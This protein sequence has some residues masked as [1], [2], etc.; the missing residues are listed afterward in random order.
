MVNFLLFDGYR[1]I[2]NNPTTHYSMDKGVNF[3]IGLVNNGAS[4][5]FVTSGKTENNKINYINDK[6]ITYDF[7]EKIDIL[8]IIREMTIEEIFKQNDILFDILDKKYGNNKVYKKLKI[9][10]KSD[11]PGWIMNK[12][13]R[14][15]CREKYKDISKGWARK[16]FDFV[17][18]QSESFK[19][20]GKEMMGSLNKLIYSRMGVPNQS[21]NFSL[22][23]NPYTYDHTYCVEDKKSLTEDRAYFPINYKE[24]IDE[25]NKPGKKIIIYTGRLKNDSGKIIYNM[26]NIM[27]KLG[28]NYELHIFPGSFYI[29]ATYDTSDN[30]ICERKD[31]SAKNGS[32][33][34]ELQNMFNGL[35]NVIV[36]YPYQH[37]DMFKYLIHADCGIDFSSSRPS[38]EISIAG[39]AKLLEYCY[40]GVPIV[41]EENICNIDIV[42]NTNN[43]ILLRPNASDEEYID[44]IKNITKF[45]DYEKK[46]NAHNITTK[47]ESWDKI[48]EKF[49]E[50]IKHLI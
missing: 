27:Q 48:T 36:H 30:I 5:Y 29:P 12:T 46:I 4:V 33:L 13:F 44:A 37:N 6:E 18:V 16:V 41:T 17:C 40:S 9:G 31:C 10:V 26:R 24:K 39:H 21:I 7:L 11:S 20:L 28:N 43:C 15:L 38:S 25:F 35:I 23:K 45:K 49:L 22:Y 32:H 1:D 14:N 19:E 3:G 50:D 8:L 34:L 42:K 47:N 2:I